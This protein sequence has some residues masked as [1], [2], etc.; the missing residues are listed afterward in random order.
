MENTHGN[1]RSVVA[2]EVKALMGRH[3]VSKADPTAKL[4][5]PKRPTYVPRP[6]PTKALMAAIAA[7]PPRERLM[8]TLAGYAG[9]RCAEIADLR[10]NPDEIGWPSTTAWVNWFCEAMGCRPDTEITVIRWEYL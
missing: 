3:S 7:A 1:T 6:I 2:G 10:L 5:N 9:L 4:R 8:L